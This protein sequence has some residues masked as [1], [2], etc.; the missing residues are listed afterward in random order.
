MSQI[1]QIFFLLFYVA[2]SYAITQERTRLIADKVQRS[3][4]KNQQE[5]D[6]SLK[7]LHDGFPN[8]REAKPKS[9]CVVDI[10]NNPSRCHSLEVRE[11]VSALHRTSLRS[12]SAIRRLFGR[13]PP[14]AA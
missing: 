3:T 8:F 13:P 2:S 9:I 6:V 5:L 11:R 12:L 4:A 10:G 7:Y 1:L 14:L